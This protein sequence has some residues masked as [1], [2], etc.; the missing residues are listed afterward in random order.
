MNNYKTI[1]WIIL[2]WGTT[3]FRAFAMSEDGELVDRVEHKLGLLQVQDGNFADQL[4][5]VLS[6]WLGEFEHLPI[7][8]AG[9]VGSAQ[10]WVN[11]PYVSTPV[12]LENLARNTYQFTLPWGAEATIIPGISHCDESGSYD[13]M[14]GEEVQLFGLLEITGKST[15][16]AA[17]PG[18][19][20]KHLQLTDNTL[21]SFK[22]YMTGELF[23]ALSDH[24]ILGRG[25][26]EQYPSKAAF[27]RGI[28]ESEAGNLTN[29]IFKARTHRLFGLLDD[30][31]VHEYLSGLLIGN[32][33]RELNTQHIYFIGSKSLCM[34]YERTCQLLNKTSEHISG[35]ESF[36]AGM[37]K[38]KE[39]MNN[40]YA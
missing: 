9:M 22:T 32:E 21:S 11:V 36:L 7:Y 15:I 5:A 3:N 17:F 13:V 25:L 37:L 28:L 10:G 20:C 35:D 39:A 23:S 24:T 1:D 8:M 2:D 31:E 27:E 19:H 18:T 40:D 29:Q 12:K 4:Q 14:R 38:I 34:R 26:P 33:I 16:E 30:S 6:D